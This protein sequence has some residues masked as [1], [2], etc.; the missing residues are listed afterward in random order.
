MAFFWGLLACIIVGALA[1]LHGIRR[2]KNDLESKALSLLFK[3][4]ELI[5]D[6]DNEK[7]QKIIS[8][9]T[10]GEMKIQNIIL[11]SDLE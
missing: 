3:I 5:K 2:G 6:G 1:E 8:R 7:A 11:L 9:F 4:L 10:S